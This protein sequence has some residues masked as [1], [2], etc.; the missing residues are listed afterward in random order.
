M[1]IEE[2]YHEVLEFG[3]KLMTFIIRALQ[4]RPAYTKLVE[5][6]KTEYP[7]AGDFLLPDGE[8]AVR[9]TFEEAKRLLR[10]SGYKEEEKETKE[11][12]ELPEN[13]MED[14]K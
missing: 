12:K 11:L 7:E 10:E 9:I 4:T 6:V 14:I 2:S 5:I 13:D 8:S 1:E 3:E